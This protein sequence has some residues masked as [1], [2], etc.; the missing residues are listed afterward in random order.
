M[1]N[2]ASK[3]PAYVPDEQVVME[4]GYPDWE[5]HLVMAQ[6]RI[7]TATPEGTFQSAVRVLD[8]FAET[9]VNGLWINPIW[10]RRTENRASFGNNGYGNFGIHLIDTSLTGE[11]TQEGCMQVVRRFVEEA[12]KRNIRVIFDAVVWGT[13]K[14][15][16]L[17]TEHPEFFEQPLRECWG[18]WAFDWNS[19]ALK[20]FYTA[21]AVK[22]IVET[23]A[24]GFRVDLAPDTSGYYFKEIVDAC[25]SCGRKIMVMAECES[26]HKGA[27]HINEVDVGWGP[28]PIPWDKPEEM[29]ARRKE[30]GHHSEAFFRNNIVDCVRTG[31]RVGEYQMQQTGHGGDLRY[32]TFNLLNH[33][34]HEPAVRGNRL[35]IAYQALFSPFIPLWWIGEEWNNPVEMLFGDAGNGIVMYFNRINWDSIDEPENRA[36]F[37]DVKRYIGI[38]RDHADVFEQ[39]A[40]RTRD[41]NIEKV[42]SRYDGWDNPLQ[43]YARFIPGKAVLIIPN[44][45]NEPKTVTVTPEYE[46]IGLTGGGDVRVTDLYSGEPVNTAG[47]PWAFSVT[48]RP[49]DV[50][51]YLLTEAK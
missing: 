50:G 29:E 32:Y 3:L 39:F 49:Q 33:D 12:H 15:S 6:F 30:Y 5:K 36:F 31:Y 19:R 28:T 17:V 11:E 44:R 42:I 20:D 18:G 34:D 7:E 24:D 51:V 26:Q 8:H 1:I 4:N 27:F 25:L 48:V 16:P 9:G 35:K 22:F 2:N 46:R 14:K 38:R 10:Q 13:S 40:P 21:A 45:E 41:A 43:A 23:G 37:E 47:R